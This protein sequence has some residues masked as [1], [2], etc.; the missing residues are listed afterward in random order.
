MIKNIIFDLGN[1]LISFRPS[2]YLESKNYPVEI[3]EKIITD[4]FNGPEWKMLDAGEILTTE[5]IDLIS[6][7]SSLKK[8]E[9]AFIFN[10]RTEIMFPLEFNTR[11]LPAL[12]KQGFRIFYLSNFPID[13]FEE[14]K[15]DYYFFKHFDGGIISSEVKC[16]KPDLKIFRLLLEKYDLS[17]EE[18]LY[19]DDT[20]I[21]V[22]AANS[23]GMSGFFTSGSEDI[24][25]LLFKHL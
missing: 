16:S 15:H 23:I 13:I 2:K 17:A 1:V 19:V 18:C 21:N 14:I 20:E 5:A 25:T 12:K 11:L 7:K 3:R 24:S 10:K 8:E 6:K 9:I 4:I 22:T